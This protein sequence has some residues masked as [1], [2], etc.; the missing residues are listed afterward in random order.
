M[1]SLSTARRA[2]HGDAMNIPEVLHLH[3]SPLLP[4][5]NQLVRLQFTDEARPIAGAG[6]CVQP[7]ILSLH[8]YLL[9]LAISKQLRQW[10]FLCSRPPPRKLHEF[11]A[12][13]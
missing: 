3:T 8:S 1:P 6:D 11:V 4:S 12:V 7:R 9:Y 13:C 10:A 2:L 5:F